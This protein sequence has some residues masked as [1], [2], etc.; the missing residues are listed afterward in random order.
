MVNLIPV[1]K[2]FIIMSLDKVTLTLVL[3]LCSMPVVSVEYTAT[4]TLKETWQAAGSRL[5]C[6]LTQAIENYGEVFFSIRPEEV[7]QFGLYHKNST[8]NSVEKANLSVL[9]GPW[10]HEYPSL[11]NYPVYIERRKGVKY[12]SVFDKNA[13]NIAVALIAKQ[14]PVF[15]YTQLDDSQKLEYVKVISSAIKFSDSYDEFM[16]CRAKLLPYALASF[17]D[18]VFYYPASSS[19]VTHQSLSD[20]AKIIAYLKAMP[21]AKLVLASETSVIGKADKKMYQRRAKNIIGFLQKKGIKKKRISIHASY[22]IDNIKTE[23]NT[24]RLNIFGPDVLKTFKYAEGKFYLSEKDKRRLNLAALYM[25]QASKPLVIR[26]HSDRTAS[27]RNYTA[28]SEQRG[29]VIKTYLLTQGVAPEKVIVKAYGT[30]KP[31]AT[32]RTR[33]GRALNR[34]IILSFPF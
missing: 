12:F 21:K 5:Q 26:A 34:R 28:L 15:T 14:F 29:N 10:M 31:L 7:L 25:Q 33:E 23:I 9:P 17:Q 27:R 11:Q 4:F 22:P 1:L 30:R 16:A 3:A 19:T 13:E 8:L 2:K 6:E 32:N 20:L 24:V 18:K